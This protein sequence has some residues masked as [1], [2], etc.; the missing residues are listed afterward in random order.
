MCLYT[1]FI[2]IMSGTW[3]YIHL[4]IFI[5]IIYYLHSIF[6]F[7]FYCISCQVD[8]G[9]LHGGPI[10]EASPVEQHLFIYLIYADSV[11]DS[12]VHL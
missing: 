11:S 6:Y 4:Y 3:L 12:A 8:I 1:S 5:F 7:Y 10:M 9:I 2:M